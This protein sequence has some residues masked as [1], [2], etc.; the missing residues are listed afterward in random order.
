MELGVD[1]ASAFED[2]EA[3]LFAGRIVRMNDDF[4]RVA[5]GV[6]DLFRASEFVLGHSS[7]DTDGTEQGE[8]DD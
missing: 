1:L 3:V 5:H 2:G 6:V 8:D 7:L 4:Q